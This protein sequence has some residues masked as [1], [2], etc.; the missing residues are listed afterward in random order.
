MVSNNSSSDKNFFEQYYS[1]S[2]ITHQQLSTADVFERESV[3]GRHAQIIKTTKKLVALDVGCG[4]GRY[5]KY[6][7]DI[8]YFYIGVDPVAENVNKLELALITFGFVKGQDFELYSGTLESLSSG[9]LNK[10]CDMA[11]S[12]NVIHHTA[13][14]QVYVKN[15]ALCIRSGGTL[16]VVEPNPLNPLHWISYALQR[17]LKE[18][19]KFLIYNPIYLRSIF[20][21]IGKTRFSSLGPLPLR[22]MNWS[23]KFVPIFRAWVKC[24]WSPF[25]PFFRYEVKIS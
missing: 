1:S 19:W 12:I 25:D 9:I 5:A 22:V 21:F 8:G 6:L 15:L 18:E 20:N 2:S 3:L 11:L 14:A 10:K 24:C 4:Y 16:I 7:I 17:S 13:S 23:V